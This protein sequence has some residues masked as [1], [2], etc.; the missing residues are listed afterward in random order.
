[1]H[2]ENSIMN[3]DWNCSISGFVDPTGAVSSQHSNKHFL[4]LNNCIW[5]NPKLGKRINKIIG[6]FFNKTISSGSFSSFCALFVSTSSEVD[7]NVSTD[8]ETK[9]IKHEPEIFDF[10]IDSIS[11]SMVAKNSNKINSSAKAAPRQTIID[12]FAKINEYKEDDSNVLNESS[13]S[14]Q[15]DS[16]LNISTDSLLQKDKPKFDS[17][18]SNS[19]FNSSFASPKFRRSLEPRS[20]LSP[21]PAL[22]KNY[23]L[24][25]MGSAE[26][27]TSTQKCDHHDHEILIQSDD[28]NRETFSPQIST[29]KSK[30]NLI[31]RVPDVLSIDFDDL[32]ERALKSLPEDETVYGDSDEEIFEKPIC[33]LIE[34]NTEKLQERITRDI[35]DKLKVIGQFNNGFI[36]AS[37]GKDVFIIDQHGADERFNFDHYIT[38]PNYSHQKLVV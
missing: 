9:F 14:M 32:S 2:V 37:K 7:H 8:K 33:L 4:Y 31:D 17:P 35:F 1:M 36:I 28:E 38:N 23:M 24:H 21:L 30:T 6:Q 20:N 22:P 18:R 34:K 15:N 27:T 25:F 19:S 10:V 13:I 26:K 12:G 5:N 16:A 11:E 29:I 3:D